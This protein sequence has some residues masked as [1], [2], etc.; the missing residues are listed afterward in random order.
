MRKY[1][2][3]QLA[4]IAISLLVATVLNWLLWFLI[5]GHPGEIS[6]LFHILTIICL[7]AAFVHIGDSLTKAGIYR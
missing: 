1:T 5:M 3:K 7:A 6:S 4:V 2:G